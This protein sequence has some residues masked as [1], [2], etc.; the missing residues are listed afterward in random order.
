[1]IS[2]RQLPDKAI[3]LIDES[4]SR[5]RME[6]DS[7]PEE[8]DALRRA[9]DRLKMEEAYLV[10]S[11][12]SDDPSAQ[13]RLERLRAELA[14]RSEELA[15]LTARW[16]TE[17]AGHNRVGDLKQRLDALRTEAERAEREG[18]YEDAGRLRYGEIPAVEREI[19]EAE[20]AEATEAGEAPMSAGRVSADEVAHVVASWTGIPVGRLLAGETDKL[21]RMADVLGQPPI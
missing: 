11:A 16:E 9:V 12:D 3:D 15:A 18:R 8:I 6:L 14:D 21:L 13:G 20:A 2:G 1:Y 7:S 17:K 10:E 5:L 19:R 4:A